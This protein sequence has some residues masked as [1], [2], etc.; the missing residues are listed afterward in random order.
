[1]A[2]ND[3]ITEKLGNHYLLEAEIRLLEHAA[4]NG[5]LDAAVR[6]AAYC[7]AM[8]ENG[9]RL[10]NP[11]F[12]ALDKLANTTGVL[13]TV[14]AMAT[15]SVVGAL[16]FRES[17]LNIPNVI[18]QGRQ[19]EI[20]ILRD[21]KDIN[22]LFA[23]VAVISLLNSPLAKIAQ[24]LT[25]LNLTLPLEDPNNP[26]PAQRHVL[27]A[28]YR[29]SAMHRLS[30]RYAERA[31]MLY[32]GMLMLATTRLPE[33]PGPGNLMLNAAREEALTAEGIP[34]ALPA[35]DEA[36]AATQKP[37]GV[38]SMTSATENSG[39]AFSYTQDAGAESSLLQTNI[40]FEN[41][42]PDLHIQANTGATAGSPT[43]TL[44]Y[45]ADAHIGSL[46]AIK[47]SANVTDGVLNIDLSELTPSAGTNPLAEQRNWVLSV[48]QAFKN[49]GVEIRAIGNV[50][51]SQSYVNT[52]PWNQL[53]T[54]KTELE[55]ALQLPASK[56]T[57][58]EL[59]GTRQPDWLSNPAAVDNIGNIGD[60]TNQT[61]QQALRAIDPRIQKADATL[62]EELKIDPGDS[63]EIFRQPVSVTDALG[64]HRSYT[65]LTI[66]H[67][68]QEPRIVLAINEM[69]DK[70][71]YVAVP[72]ELL[73]LH[74]TF[75]ETLS[76]PEMAEQAGKTLL[77]QLAEIQKYGSVN[78]QHLNTAL[79][80][81]I[82]QK[83]IALERAMEAAN[84]I[85]DKAV[86]MQFP[87]L[88]GNSL[89]GT[90]RRAT[91]HGTPYSFLTIQ[92]GENTQTVL[93]IKL[94]NPNAPAAAK[95]LAVPSEL[96]D[97]VNQLAASGPM[98]IADLQREIHTAV[99]ESLSLQTPAHN[100]DIHTGQTT[101][102]NTD[103]WM[104]IEKLP[105]TE[106]LAQYED[107]LLGRLSQQI[108]IENHV[109]LPQAAAEPMVSAPPLYEH[110]VQDA[111][112]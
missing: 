39:N 51:D 50:T 57:L 106:Y 3:T 101:Y 98:S 94:N 46:S 11:Q 47:I 13:E 79:L 89:A 4:E 21:E 111:G 104:A 87:D 28:S 7:A 22:Q 23:K 74:N 83:G 68:S 8:L 61:E 43:H 20:N 38:M 92:H 60:I 30:E 86:L 90:V 56:Q 81:H 82:Q 100:F 59:A 52:H 42:A 112:R 77:S 48:A 99:A 84:K 31:E 26:S 12:V 9:V 71:S 108:G 64:H 54:L 36:T 97:K 24:S 44:S 55:S 41:H 73:K 103:K 72:P 62:L 45:S 25:N 33:L 40:S 107:A 65:F 91:V 49:E 110:P 16:K 63:V 27:A 18:T 93:E 37:A 75:I 66:S 14:A 96:I 105:N 69:S 78:A 10:D 1:M 95:H 109:T 32:N 58:A 70:A 34:F 85:A 35:P 15:G 17:I 6:A 67:T 19:N 102:A 29:E 5:D 53:T 76:V 80:T 2:A 88:S